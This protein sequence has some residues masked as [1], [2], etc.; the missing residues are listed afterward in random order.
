M[1]AAAREISSSVIPSK[2]LSSWAAVRD[3]IQ[4]LTRDAVALL[5][6]AMEADHV[7]KSESFPIGRF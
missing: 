3:V 1:L 6:A 7:V 5:P 2:E 4:T